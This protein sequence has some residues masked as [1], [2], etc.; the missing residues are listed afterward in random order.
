MKSE[1]MKHFGIR[2]E[3]LLAERKVDRSYFDKQVGIIAQSRYDW[4][5]GAVPNAVTAL[6]VARFFGVTVEYLLTGKDENPLGET[7]REL[8][9]RIDGIKDF[10]RD[11]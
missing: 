2:V 1:T 8:Q 6:K 10:V 9:A 11:A 5:K 3:E 7:V 4:K